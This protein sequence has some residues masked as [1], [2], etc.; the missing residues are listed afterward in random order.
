[1]ILNIKKKWFWFKCLQR[2]DEVDIQEETEDGKKI[3]SKIQVPINDEH[4]SYVCYVQYVG[5][6]WEKYPEH[7]PLIIH[8]N[9]KFYWP[10]DY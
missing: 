7:Y 10:G 6:T 3:K 9:I 4:G 8:A 2:W 5:Y 1:M